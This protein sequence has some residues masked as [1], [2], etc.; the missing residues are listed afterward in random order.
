MGLMSGW[1]SRSTVLRSTRLRFADVMHDGLQFA[2]HHHRAD[3]LLGGNLLDGDAR[4]RLEVDGAG[5][6]VRRHA[7]HPVL[8]LGR[9]DAEFVLQRRRASTAPRSADIPGTPTRLPLRSAG[10]SMPASRRASMSVW[11]NLRVVKIGSPTQRSSPR[12]FAII[13]DDIDISETSKSANLQLPPEHF[14]GMQ[15]GGH[16]IDA[17]GRRRCRRGSATTSDWRRWRG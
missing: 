9:R 11:K 13:S 4:R 7:L 2:R 5:M 8:H 6:A 16:E 14:R 10:L 1:F 3:A 17:V 15:D 12:D